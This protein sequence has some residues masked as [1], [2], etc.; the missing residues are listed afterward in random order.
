MLLV[1]ISRGINS[2]LHQP[3]HRMR[4]GGQQQVS[5]LVRDDVSQRRTQVRDA[6]LSGS[7]HLRQRDPGE[8]CARARAAGRVLVHAEL[9]VHG[10]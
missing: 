5:D 4:V 1:A 8:A 10:R 3:A 9:A 6:L 2:F 7:L